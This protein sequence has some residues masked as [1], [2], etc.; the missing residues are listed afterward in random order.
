MTAMYELQP[1]DGIELLVTWLAPL[2]GGVG[3]QRYSGEPLPYRWVSDAGGGVD[4]KVTSVSTF[5]I[6]T[7][8]ADYWEARAQARLTHRRMLALGPPLAGQQRV[9][10][11]GNRIAFVDGIETSEQPTWQDYGDNT[12]HRFV[13]RYT[14]D[15]R[16]VVAAGS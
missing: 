16:F 11:A 5:S 1:P 6:H 15:L 12:V 10:L 14:I 8:A 2:D 13:A 4:D 7:F 9:A 3:P